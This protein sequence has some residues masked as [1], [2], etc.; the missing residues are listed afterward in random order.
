MHARDGHVD[1]LGPPFLGAVRRSAVC[2][3]ADRLAYVALAESLP[4][5]V[6]VLVHRLAAALGATDPAA[7]V[8]S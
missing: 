6:V 8:A 2:S 1:E 7:V 5:D 4:R 3:S